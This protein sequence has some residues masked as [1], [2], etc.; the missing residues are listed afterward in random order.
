MDKTTLPGV[1]ISQVERTHAWWRYF[2]PIQSR[3]ALLSTLVVQGVGL[4]L[5]GL[6]AYL[7][8]PHVLPQIVI[9]AAA[10]GLYFG[11]YP[12]LPA[13]LTLVTRSEARH[14]L[15]DMQAR[16]VQLRYVV[17]EQ[18][19]RPGRFHYRSKRSRLWRWDEED[20]ELL[21][22]DHELVLN[23]PIGMLAY[24]RAKLLAPED[25]SYLNKKA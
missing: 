18:E 15:D 1:T 25:F 7:A 13:R 21:V 16:L 22:R 9:G 12:Y 6:F 10:C 23:G 5:M 2:W 11:L 14:H 20:I 8:A 4:P 24:L 3:R 17:S 19:R